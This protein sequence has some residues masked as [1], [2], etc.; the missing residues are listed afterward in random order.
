MNAVRSNP[1]AVDVLGRVVLAAGAVACGAGVLT[2]LGWAIGVD[3]LM[4]IRPGYLP[5]AP[6][7]ALLFVLLGSAMMLREFW[8]ACRVIGRAASAIA[9]FSAAL[10]GMT[11][12]GFATGHD[13]NLD[14]WLFRTTRMLGQVP[15]GRMSPLTAFCFLL[16]G[17][18]LLML[19]WRAMAW[20]AILGILIAFVGVVCV[21]GYGYG[22][23]L[24]YGGTV[25]PMA[26]ST[27]LAFVALGVGLTA[28]AGPHAWPVKMLSGPST[29]ARLLRALLPTVVALAL[30]HDWMIATLLGHSAPGVVLTSAITTMLILLAVGLVVSRVSIVIGDAID[31]AEAVREQAV[32]AL[33]ESEARFRDLYEQAPLAYQSLDAAGNLLEVNEAWLALLGRTRDEVIGRFIGDFMTEETLGTLGHEFPRFKERGSV[34]GP[35]FELVHKNGS[36]RLVTVNGRISHDQQGNFLRTHCILTD[37]TERK[38]AEEELRAVEEQ[39]RGLVEQT[40]TG[41]FIIQ[42]GGFVY[43]NSRTVEILGYDTADE[44]LGSDPLRAVADK[45]RATAAENIRL[46]LKREAESVRQCFTA[47]R[48]DG[49]MVEVGAHG[50]R[51]T[52]HDRPAVIGM[53]QDISEKKNAEEKIRRYVT[54]LERAIMATVGVATAIG[55]MRD[56]YTTGHERRVAE[57]SVAIGAEFG[58]DARR[59]EGLRVAGYLHDVGKVAIP[60]E[61]LSKPAKLTPVEFMLIQG[62]PQAGYDVLKSAEFP[63]PVAEIVLQH[64]ERMDGSGYPRGLKGEAILLEAR[65]LAVADTVE[66]MSS[67]RPYRPSQG[68]E[69]ALAEIEK[70]SGS[71]YDPDVANAC[72]RLFRNEGYQIPEG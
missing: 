25:I 63:W 12:L 67:H 13:W 40:L 6:N 60:A 39:F 15:V 8:P 68:I 1:G 33:Q 41:I 69:K 45:D 19:E 2:L 43:V 20:A 7:A 28:A 10:A 65:I 30:L 62:H 49:S 16:A 61:I 18:S 70:G 64:H 36:H 54:Q 4:A 50:V 46:L 14:E 71:V 55:E 58:L 22:A 44:L 35:V 9:L 72:L 31:R 26:L 32:E 52:H 3:A 37:I 56:P 34:Q 5:M 17:G 38:R 66:A 51:G 53:M 21:I 42:D 59:L 29:R 24:L 48:K 47:L 23:P 57:I 11:L 27:A